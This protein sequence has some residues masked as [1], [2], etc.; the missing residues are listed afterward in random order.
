VVL[1]NNIFSRKNGISQ[2]LLYETTLV[3]NGGLAAAKIIPKAIASGLIRGSRT[4]AI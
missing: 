4:I 1:V 2:K 3:E